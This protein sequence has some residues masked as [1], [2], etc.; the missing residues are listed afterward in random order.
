MASQEER[1]AFVT[2]ATNDTYALGCLVLGSSL[3]RVETTRKLAVMVTPGVSQSLR[4]QLSRVFN[5][6]YDVDLLDSQD[7]TNLQLLGRPDLNV[8]FTKFHC[9]RLTQYDKAV[10][11]DADTL[12]LQ[13]VDELFNREE[14]SA[15]PDAG[16]PDCFNSG[17]FVFKPSEQT[18]NAILQFALDQ[19]SFDGGD[20]GLLNMF[21][22]EWATQDISRHLPFVYNVVSQAFYSY[23]PAF[24]QFKNNVKI[25]HFI[26]ATKPWH[27]PFNTSSGE[28]TP[29]PDSG[30]NQEFLQLWWTIFMEDVQQSLDP[31]LMS[32]LT[33]SQQKKL[34]NREVQQPKPIFQSVF[35]FIPPTVENVYYQ[36]N[37]DTFSEKGSKPPQMDIPRSYTTLEGHYAEEPMTTLDTSTPSSHIYDAPKVV[38]TWTNNKQQ[39][40]QHN[41]HIDNDS[42]NCSHNDCYVHVKDPSGNHEQISTDNRALQEQLNQNNQMNV[43]NYCSEENPTENVNNINSEEKTKSEEGLIGQLA[44]LKISRDQVPAHA[45][46]LSSGER[47]LNWEKGQIDYLGED[48]FVNIQKK[49][50]ES[51][52]KPAEPHKPATSP[53]SRP[54]PPEEPAETSKESKQPCE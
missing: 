2:L 34:Y 32:M 6:V 15:A 28:V 25:V 45:S 51:L 49:L 7:P 5:L 33:T 42:Q 17:V 24:K 10:F 44:T 47:K 20:Q 29:L 41:E 16:W 8:T 30:H 13:N 26:G 11:L 54:S 12:V 50:E 4:D 19:G 48:S 38:Q 52:S 40:R 53:F 36:E 1:E 9:W 23:L 14:L 22:R 27:Q 21:F 37:P 35:P 18:Y 3:R 39:N 46:A 31:N 43:N